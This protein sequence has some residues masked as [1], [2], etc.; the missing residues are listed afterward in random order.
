M[1]KYKYYFRKP[2]SEI[3]K[4]VLRAALVTGAITIAAT[5]PYFVINLLNGCRKFNKYPKPK[6]SDAFSRL[7]RQG[8]ISVEK[9]GRQIHIKL[10]PEGKKKA[11]FYQVNDLSVKKPK[12][13]DSRWRLVIFD[14]SESKRIRREAFRGKLKELGFR[15]IQKSVWIHPFPCQDEITLLRDFFGLDKNDI[16]L[17]VAEEI[18]KE[19]ELRKLFNL[20]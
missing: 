19:V 20:N 8:L 7:K 17:V 14:I 13:W 9:T 4:D 10:T 5:S 3:V 11:G 2:K 6:I 16:Q 12:K 1:S 15:V 18:E